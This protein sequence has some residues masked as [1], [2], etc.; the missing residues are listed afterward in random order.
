[1]I[2]LKVGSLPFDDEIS[3][4][5]EL[6]HAASGG[7]CRAAPGRQRRVAAQM[8]R[9]TSLQRLAEFDVTV[10]EQPIPAGRWQEMAE[11]CALAH[12]FPSPW[13]RN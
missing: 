7:Q 4:L 11:P 5:A 9:W 8:R 13:T 10:L 6:R 3:L 1:M 2:K 12:P